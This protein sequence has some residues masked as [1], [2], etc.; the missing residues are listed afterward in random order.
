MTLNSDA[1][2]EE[3]PISCFKNDK[4]LVKFVLSIQKSQ[5][6]AL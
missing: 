4:N 2:Y 3:K 5:N 1:Q 6:V